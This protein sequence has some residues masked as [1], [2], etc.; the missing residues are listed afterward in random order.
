MYFQAS[1]SC[2]FF[3]VWLQNVM[4]IN[5]DYT[6]LTNIGDTVGGCMWKQN[7]API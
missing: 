7:S 1:N 4:E 2:T 6:I 3:W 5:V